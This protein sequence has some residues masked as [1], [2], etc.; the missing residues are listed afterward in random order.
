MPLVAD[1]DDTKFLCT[2]F[3]FHFTF[4]LVELMLYYV[5]M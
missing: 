5:Y 1:L 3:A 2:H 4:H